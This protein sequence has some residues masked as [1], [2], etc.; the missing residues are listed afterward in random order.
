MINLRDLLYLVNLEKAANFSRA[1]ELSF[2]S[3]PTLSIQIK[4]LEERLGVQLFERHKKNVY[5][6]AAGVHVALYAKKILHMSEE[7]TNSA[8]AFANPL[9]GS[10]RMGIFP[11]LAP[12]LLPSMIPKV[13]QSMPN[14][15]L[16]LHEEKSE[17]CI[18]QL[19]QG[20]WDGILLAEPLVDS[21][22]VCERVFREDFYLAMSRGHRLANEAVVDVS[23]IA[24]EE[25]MLVH[26][27]HC[28]GKQSLDYCQKLSTSS[29][30]MFFG[31]NLESLLGMIAL[32]RGVTLVPQLSL[33]H[34][35]RYHLI[36]RP[37]KVPF[38]RDIYFISRKSLQK[39]ATVAQWIQILKSVKNTQ[40][41]GA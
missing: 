36:V 31:T 11:T 35:A 4:K 39:E 12:Y 8:A 24:P 40:A 33:T 26:Q 1:A 9:E 38:Y 16:S 3:Q 17:V 37:L 2:V 21:H 13:Q 25:M 14:L 19:M 10:W 41:G 30:A 29:Q 27:G 20:S 6:T 28:M 23:A 32:G 22:L 34:V 15:Q 18:E 7:L 5:L